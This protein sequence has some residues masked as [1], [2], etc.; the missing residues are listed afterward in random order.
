MIVS[1]PD[2]KNNVMMLNN[3][4]DVTR[5]SR[6]DGHALTMGRVPLELCA[7]LRMTA[8][9]WFVLLRTLICLMF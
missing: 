5:P 8:L 7:P 4:D 1:N 9:A 3:P 2:S 6:R